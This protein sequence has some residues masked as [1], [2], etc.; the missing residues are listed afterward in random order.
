MYPFSFSSFDLF[1]SVPD[2]RIRWGGRGFLILFLFFILVS[3]P[4]SIRMDENRNRSK[5]LR[6]E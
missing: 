3:P 6:I 2:Y 4:L 5:Y 1:G